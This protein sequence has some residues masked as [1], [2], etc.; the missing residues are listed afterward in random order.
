MGCDGRATIQP[1]PVTVQI[2]VA[3]PR[4]GVPSGGVPAF[5]DG[6]VNEALV[7]IGWDGR[8][9]SKI[10]AA[11]QYAPDGLALQLQLHP[12]IKFH[13]GTPVTSEIVK[14]VLLKVIGAQGRPLS[15]SSIIEIRVVDDRVLEL[16]LSRPESFLLSDLAGSSI[17]HLDKEQIG[18]GPYR[19][20]DQKDQRDIARLEAFQ[21]YYRGRPKTDRVEVKAYRDQRSS[22][23]ALMR[24]EINALHEVSSG[25]AD[26][27]EAESSIRTFAFLRPY[28]AFLS[29]NLNHP[30]LSRTDVR[31]ALSH[32][33][34]RPQVVQLALRGRGQPADGPIWPFH[35]AYSTGHKSYS[36]NPEAAR[37]VLDAA[38]FPVPA[39]RPIGRMPSRLRFKC[40][41]LSDYARFE[42]MGLVMQ[43]QLFDVGVDMELEAVPLADFV[44]R[45]ITGQFDTLLFEWAS[46]RTLGWVYNAWHSPAPGAMSP[47]PGY[48]AADAV[49]DRLRRSTNE[50]EIR[51]AVSELQRVLYEDPPAVFIAWPNV[52]RAVSTAFVVPQESN[53]D[54]MG[55][56][57][58]WQPVS[59]RPAGK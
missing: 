7:G 34:N 54:V 3:L 19:L 23:A 59:G 32:A 8:A 29:F 35:W 36:Y 9:T 5:V 17:K 1:A 14:Q 57:W 20:T 45:V 30:V 56:L 58:L 49:L 6:V 22:W 43:K 25:T 21:D 12:N 28:Y 52:S 41:I 50:D 10:A 46:A 24:G 4:E 51:V 15:Y 48:R 33:I 27:V 40:L 18:V 13:D 26:F 55:S 16:H 53:P 38:G 44:K 11:W 37:L 42:T 31:Q 2:G 47:N 39:E